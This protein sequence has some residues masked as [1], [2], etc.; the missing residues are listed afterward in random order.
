MT[1]NGGI[2]M[3]LLVIHVCGLGLEVNTCIQANL[4]III[5]LVVISCHQVCVVIELTICGILGVL[6]ILEVLQSVESREIA[7]IELFGRIK[8]SILRLSQQRVDTVH[9]AVA[10]GVTILELIAGLNIEVLSNR[11]GV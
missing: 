5:K 11:L 2:N 10:I 9:R 4:L 3:I 8:A 1:H 6:N 7:Q